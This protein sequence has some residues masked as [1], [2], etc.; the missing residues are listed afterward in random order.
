MDQLLMLEVHMQDG[1][2]M[3]LGVRNIRTVWPYADDLNEG[4]APEA[5]RAEVFSVGG[6][7]SW[8]IK[9]TYG[10]IRKFFEEG[11]ELL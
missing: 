6:K 9:E 10:Q 4:K 1:T 5:C 3:M 8:V 7:G 2:P 11:M